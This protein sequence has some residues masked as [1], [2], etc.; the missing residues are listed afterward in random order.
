MNSIYVLIFDKYIFDI[1]DKYSIV[2]EKSNIKIYNDDKS[3]D[4]Y[5]V[6]IVTDDIII[7]DIIKKNDKNRLK[8]IFKLSNDCDKINV[9]SNK[10]DNIKIYVLPF[11]FDDIAD[12]IITYLIMLNNQ[13][14]KITNT[15]QLMCKS[16]SKKKV[17]VVGYNTISQFI[18]KKMSLFNMDIYVYDTMFGLTNAERIY[19]KKTYNG[20]D[21]LYKIKFGE[22][23]S[24]MQN[25][26][27]IIVACDLNDNTKNLI[28]RNNLCYCNKGV[29]IINIFN[30]SV[31][32]ESDVLELIEDKIDNIASQYYENE[33]LDKYNKN[34]VTFRI[35]LCPNVTEEII[36]VIIKNILSNF[37][38]KSKI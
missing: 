33:L 3:I 29:K 9:L 25:A 35:N 32:N 8:I 16:L 30:S 12:I 6:F 1:L 21:N 36:S 13:M 18:I 22:L 17:C 11:S 37:H 31:I 26:D 15:H 27:F 38:T 24:C 7:K 14:Y 19:N 23:H 4:K 34:F 28:N 10:K 5:D 20:H 2:F